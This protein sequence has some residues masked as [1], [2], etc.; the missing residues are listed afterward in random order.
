MKD[1]FARFMNY[2]SRP[3]YT[4]LYAVLASIVVLGAAYI[5]QYGFGLDPC[6]LCYYQRI[7]YFIV[8]GL[9]AAAFFIAPSSE[10]GAG[11][12]LTLCALTF[13][14]GAGLAAFHVGVEQHWWKGLQACGNAAM[15]VGA[16]VDEMRAFIMSRDIVRCDVPA[17]TLF[18]IS[19]AGFNFLISL[20]LFMDLA[21]LMRWRCKRCPAGK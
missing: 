8:I 20:G 14:A 13:L 11:V 5:S 6:I 9:G 12:L 3:R 18:G 1:I 2:W 7:P 19:M 21:I 17:F 16:S 4:A 10:K 15:P